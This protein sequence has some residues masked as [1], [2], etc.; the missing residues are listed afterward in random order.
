[1]DEI[2]S[3][4]ASASEN[5]IS[6]IIQQCIADTHPPLFDIILHFAMILTDDFEYTARYLAFIFGV[7]GIGATYYYTRK[8]TREKWTA[9]FAMGVVALNYF[10]IIYSFEGR[11]YS[12][13][14]LL[15]IISIS[16]LYLYLRD[17][18]AR[19]LFIFIVTN[20]FFVY[21][22][23]YGSIS[24][25]V[26]SLCV[27]MLLLTRAI[28]MKRFIR[29][30]LGCVVVLLA[31]LPWLPNMFGKA[32]TTGWIT[33]P[34][35]ADFF[36]YFYTYTGKNPLEFALLFIPLLLAIP[37]FRKDRILYTILYGAI[38]MGFAV[39]FIVSHLSTPLLHSRY[40]FIY[41]PA[42]YL[43]AALAWSRFTGVG[44][45]TKQWAYGAVIVAIFINVLFI[46]NPYNEEFKDPYKRIGKYLAEQ[47]AGRVLTQHNY[48]DYYLKRQ[49]LPTSQ[50][51]DKVSKFDDEFW[52]LVTPY[53]NEDIWGKKEYEIIQETRF[54]NGFV[55]YKLDIMK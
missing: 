51:L 36:T 28:D 26:L 46:R 52:Y 50:S 43:L 21:T 44:H 29:Y 15:S 18:K 37:L 39:P 20:V 3:V 24:L 16:E 41:L 42:V 33:E 47:K 4:Q 53:D 17:Y 22:H 45:R 5:S 9:L 40:T 31:Y 11:F 6:E 32:G 10:H 48:I 38:L 8:I 13:I 35:I 1:M 2:W 55:L 49:S 34:S 27:L 23:Y 12:L 30:A 54:W 7:I 19:H 25:F 14:Y